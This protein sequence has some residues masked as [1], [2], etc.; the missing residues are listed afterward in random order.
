MKVGTEVPQGTRIVSVDALVKAITGVLLT[1]ALG[2]TGW[3][4]TTVMGH[5]DR[6][7]RLE[8]NESASTKTLEVLQRQ[9][10]AMQADL[11]YVREG[12]VSLETKLTHLVQAVDELKK[13][14]R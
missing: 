12:F 1:A 5:G 13:Q 2:A 6:L 10:A 8:T 3:L 11:R 14:L 4:T 9:Y 7:T